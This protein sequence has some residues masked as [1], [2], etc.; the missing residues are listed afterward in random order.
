MAATVVVPVLS[1]VQPRVLKVT[2]TVPTTVNGTDGATAT[3]ELPKAF[4][5]VWNAVSTNFNAK[6]AELK[7]STDGTNYYALASANQLSAS[8]NKPIPQIECGYL[9]WQFSFTGAP[10]ATLVVTVIANQL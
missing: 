4:S 3:F 10:V 8:G 5:I 6:T 1:I 9:Y 2:I 7:A